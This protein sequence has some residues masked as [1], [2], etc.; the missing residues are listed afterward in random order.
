M[1]SKAYTKTTTA[2]LRTAVET[3]AGGKFVAPQAVTSDP[4]GFTMGVGDYSAVNISIP[5]KFKM[6]MS[7]QEVKSLLQQQTGLAEAAVTRVAD[8]GQAA[9]QS[10]MSGIQSARAQE[11]TAGTG[12]PPNWQRYLPLIIVAAV[13][14]LGSRKGRA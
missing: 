2:D 8:F 4:G 14:I 12:E 7:G 3:T 13:V 10:A 1:G 9:I 11:L 6:G 5:G